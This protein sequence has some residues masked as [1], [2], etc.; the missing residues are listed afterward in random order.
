MNTII[1]KQEGNV[2]YLTLNRK[3]SYNAVDLEMLTELE[4]LFSELLYRDDLVVLIL[5]GGECRGFCAGL[6]M[7]TFGPDIFKM[8]PSDMYNTQ[9]RLSRLLLSMRNI[10]QPIIAAIHGSAAGLGF[11]MAM[12][13][14][15]R[16]ATSDARFCAAYL[17]IGLGGAD[18][19][20][21][22]F[23]PRLIGAGRAYEFLLTGE[24]MSA[25]TALSLGFLS[26][27]VQKEELISEA[28]RIA[29][30]IVSK[31]HPGKRLTKESINLALDAPSLNACLN[32]EN[33][34]QVFLI[35]GKK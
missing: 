18:M 12:A 19:A 9:V 15:I 3:E 11:S 21:S 24:W 32:I 29:N 5:S 16:I 28:T 10:P 26:K 17:N 13:S 27:I 31:N 14:D 7:K 33:R 23:L 4:E 30:A 22:Y 8:K 6:D 2:G 35:L 1:F 34:N 20:S 25:E